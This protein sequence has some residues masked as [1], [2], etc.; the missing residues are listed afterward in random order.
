MKDI[1][2]FCV[3]MAAILGG[4]YFLI[5]WSADRAGKRLARTI[6]FGT[7][8]V[9]RATQGLPPLSREEWEKKLKK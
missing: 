9:Q 1:I 8:N 7:M 4:F 2:L 3:L 6:F 5:R